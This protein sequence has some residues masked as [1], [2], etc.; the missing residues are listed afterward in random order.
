MRHATLQ[1]VGRRSRALHGD[2]DRRALLLR[3][4]R[5]RLQDRLPGLSR[6]R[7]QAERLSAL[8]GAARA[9]VRVSI[10]RTAPLKFTMHEYRAVELRAGEVV[11]TGKQQP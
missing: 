1:T 6:P 4:P 2:A 7:R 9:G 11:E 10:A 5:P 8:G 3:Q